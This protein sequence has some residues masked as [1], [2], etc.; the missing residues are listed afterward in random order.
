MKKIAVV[1][2]TRAEYGLLTPLIRRIDED[3]ALELDLIVTGMHLSDKYGYTANAIQKDGFLIAHRIPI[4]E[5]DNTSCG[6]SITIANALR[7]FAHCFEQDHPDM[8][9]ILGDRTEMLGV[10]V[11]AMNER[12]PIE[13]INGGEVTE[14]AVDDCI[15]HELTKMSYLHFTS[16]EAYRNRVI[17]L[18]EAQ[19]RVFN[20]GALGVENIR[21]VQLMGREEL[22]KFTGVSLDRAYAVVTFHPVTLE[23]NTAVDQ[24]TEVCAAMEIRDDIFFFITA[25]NADEGGD[26]VNRLLREYAESHK[27]AKFIYS[28]GMQRY[29]SIVKYAS[30]VLGNSSS[31][32]IEV[33]SLGV[34]TVNIGVR[35][36]GRIK[37]KSVIHCEPEKQSIIAAIEKAMSKE[38]VSG[39]SNM[40]NPY[41]K[42]E[43][44]KTI[45]EIIKDF[46]FKQKIDLKKGF[47]DV[48]I[49]C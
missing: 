23:K 21:N 4:L 32:I 45:T 33:P 46:L 36:R 12:I 29:L 11:A 43:T 39:I 2:A 25:A 5:K 9:V 19:D 37:S 3:E 44:S 41:E 40:V 6:V 47:Y 18:G 8:V 30:F 48:G 17:Q 7:E 10:A 28:F 38:F 1:T 16:T 49:K 22:E 24:V 14:G 42:E 20:V 31:G 13:H 35:Q 34:P 26:E 27:N 15:R